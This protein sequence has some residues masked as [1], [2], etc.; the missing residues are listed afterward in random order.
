MK[1]YLGTQNIGKVGEFEKTWLAPFL[2]R[3]P[4]DIADPVETGKTCEDNAVLKARYYNR[5]LKSPVL[6]DDSGFFIPSLNDYPGIFSARVVREQGSIERVFEDIMQR[7]ESGARAYFL[8][9]LCFIDEQ[10]KEFIFEG[11]LEGTLS[12]PAKGDNGFGYDPIFKPRGASLSLGELVP[13]KKLEVS[14]RALALE[15]FKIFFKKSYGI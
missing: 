12:F 3:L 14:H 7:A 6:S 13:E 11:K 1:F 9:V 4:S 15:Q 8:T 10:G 2:M 5:H